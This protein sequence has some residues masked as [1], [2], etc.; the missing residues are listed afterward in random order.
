ML[1]VNNPTS[2]LESNTIMMTPVVSAEWNYNLFK[3][4]YI[5]IAGDGTAETLGSPT[6]NT[7]STSTVTKANFT[8]KEFTA[9][10]GAGTVTYPVATTSGAYAY[11]VIS[12]FRTDA[13][14][15]VLVNTSM[16]GDT[17]FQHGSHSSEIDSLGWTKIETYIG[18]N[19][20]IN[21][22]TYTI[23]A[24]ISI[25][26]GATKP[27]FDVYFTLP[28]IYP[29]TQ[30]DYQYGS[31]FSTD[32]PFEYFRPG[33]SY[34]K[35]G[36]TNIT[37]PANFRRAYEKTG[38]P[39]MPISPILYNPDFA[40]MEIPNSCIMKNG[41][42][43]NLMPYQYFI[44]DISDKNITAKYDSSITV[45][46]LVF[47]FNVTI[48]K[49]T[50]VIIKING[51]T[52]TPATA[53][54]P[55][56]NGILVLYWDGDS[57][58]TT[59]WSTMPK[60]N[61]D[62]SLSNYTTINQISISTTEELQPLF[63]TATYSAIATG[64]SRMQ[65]IEAS[66]RLEIDISEF[67]QQVNINKSLDSG[68]SQMPISSLNSNDVSLSISGIPA[69]SRSNQLVPIFS[70]Q[71][72]SANT[73][74]SGMLIK[75]VKLYINFNTSSTFEIGAGSQ[76]YPSY[77]QYIP[78][79]IFYTDTW[80]EDDI[81]NVSIQG[82]DIARYLQSLSVP[83]YVAN[84]K[85][86]F[87]IITNIMDLA[88]FTDY[89]YDSL[90]NVC[91]D[92]VSELD[93]AYY[94]CSARDKTIVAALSELF[95]AYQIGAY[96]DEYGIMKFLSLSDILSPNTVNPLVNTDI[97]SIDDFNIVENGYT[98][99][100][101]QKPGK[102]SLSY[103]PP[104]IKQSP[105]LQNI[106]NIDIKNSP[107][108][109]LTTSNDVVWSKADLDSLG[110]NYLNQ[111]MTATASYF[112]LDVNDLLDI[113]HTY[114]FNSAGYAAIEDEIVSFMNKEY[115]I[116]QASVPATYKT[117][118]VKNEVELAAQINKFTK[119]NSIG[120]VEST[121]TTSSTS[122][123]LGAGLKTFDLA[124]TAG[125]YKY[126]RVHI[127]NT[128][129]TKQFMYGYISDVIVD[130]SIT[131]RVDNFNGS[132]SVSTWT[133]A[134]IPNYDIY[135]E[136]TGNIT[137]VVR[138]A[139][140][141]RVS[142]HTI[143]PNTEGTGGV[144]AD[145]DLLEASVSSLYIIT[146]PSSTTSI[147]ENKILADVPLNSK[148]LLYPSTQRDEVFSTYS[149]KFEFVGT[150]LC[151]GGVFF[152]MPV[153]LSGDIT[154]TAEGTYFVEVVRYTTATTFDQNTVYTYL[155]FVYYIDSSNKESLIAYANITNTVSSILSNIPKTFILKS[156]PDPDKYEVDYDDIFNLRVAYQ[157]ETTD[158]GNVTTNGDNTLSIFLN[159]NLITGWQVP[160][161]LTNLIRYTSP[162]TVS[163]G[164]GTKVFSVSGAVKYV[165]PGSPGYSSSNPQY[166]YLQSAINA[167]Y[168]MYGEI[169]DV[170]TSV[171]GISTITF[172]VDKYSGSG[173]E[174]S[175]QVYDDWEPIGINQVTG[176]RK[177]LVMP[178]AVDA[179]TI[180]GSYSANKACDMI[181]YIIDSIS[182]GVAENIYRMNEL[183]ATET[184]LI[185]SSTSYYYQHRNFLN[186]TLLGQR[187]VE[188]TY[189]MQTKPEVV[190][191]NY[192]DIEYQNPAA[193]DVNIT[194]VEYLWYYLPSIDPNDQRYRQKLTVNDYDV[195]SSTVANT[196]FKGKFILVN[197]SSHLI[198]TSKEA[199]DLNQFT[200]K[201]NVWT[202]N[203]IAPSDQQLIEKVVN[204]SNSSEIV[205]IDSEWIQSDTAAYKI[206]NVIASG[207]D[208]FSKEVSLNIFGNP[209]I[210][211]GDVINLTYSLKGI[212]GQNY[213][214]RGVSQSFDQGLSTQLSLIALEASQ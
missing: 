113:F 61:T 91:N 130:T 93:V 102:I 23:N 116:Y 83:D 155:M 153:D 67:V 89:D 162:S 118:S 177:K 184:A 133:L 121:T 101:K 18:A 207:L 170:D 13:Q 31:M 51:T 144:I 43:T 60:F 173:S 160:G 30:F 76:S 163:L 32:S 187:D 164:A 122:V 71:S 192:Y 126:G 200:T 214:V 158:Q 8:T 36:N 2:F 196:G 99:N 119:E 165:D 171:P 105:S 58:E 95:M 19:E 6:G 108:F 42:P 78:G 45:N 176:I 21:S 62:G 50:E 110:F 106:Q 41:L 96:I 132:G 87:D 142:E 198:F 4:P 213:L 70:N 5:T 197:N 44:S 188:K 175:W 10:G 117:V 211:V 204:K 186:A 181:Q 73:V 35:T 183:Y 56:S 94:F 81:N 127:Y 24:S 109:V 55:D 168:Y 139:F 190:G 75:N 46:K 59:Q 12:Y 27:D 206:L 143:L 33:E 150:T 193:V 22:L 84:L 48:T 195:S 112:K 115:T 156:N 185:D 111:D 209:L 64:S 79:G 88:G 54:V 131:V 135:V 179:G 123:A 1:S 53:F 39:Y 174:S 194:P 167:D 86:V 25:T 178:I 16:A 26:N 140:N 14:Y 146:A 7:V 74:L 159:N 68:S 120:F 85:T 98:F 104:K 124:S 9:T 134:N 103:N 72:D 152:N 29:V 82:Y 37:F 49:P 154:S 47:K 97:I 180:F 128:N 201:L 20:A 191:F 136:P 172:F 38:D 77:N 203:I 147:A 202:H 129:D 100:A 182:T 125:F 90:Y 169:T 208:G 80:Q 148:V 114:S 166:I 3:S 34:I 137:E 138:G 149:T 69:L 66:P 161:R 151:V 15:P 205:Q 145:K 212:S 52:L 57:W 63:D 199:D 28:E 11:K 210:Q 107:S 92:L 65:L 189:C 40:I 17:I 157:A 141:T